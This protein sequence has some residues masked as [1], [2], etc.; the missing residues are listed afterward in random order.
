LLYSYIIN[1]ER[2]DNIVNN[3]LT[4]KKDIIYISTDILAKKLERQHKVIYNLVNIYKK[5]IEMLGALHFE[6]VPNIGEKGGGSKKIYY[7]NKK[8]YIF[9]ITNMRTKANEKTTVMNAKLEIADKFVEMEKYILNQ[10]TMKANEEYKL[11]RG[12]SILGRRQETD[13]IKEFIEYAKSQGSKSADKYYMNFS[14]MENSAFFIL[15]EKFKNVREIL[16]INQLSK[17]IIADMIVKQAIIEGMEKEM[18]YKDI[19]QE[20]KKR[21]VDLANSLGFKEVLPGIEFKQLN[22]I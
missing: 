5:E 20:A 17:I 9:L 8:Q 12:K 2:I 3:L 22:V 21:V 14:K 15:K 7:L 19:F 18:F 16:S 10:E 1:F 4:V 6:N 11:T 13:V